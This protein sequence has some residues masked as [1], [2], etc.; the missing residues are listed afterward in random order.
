MTDRITQIKNNI[1]RINTDIENAVTNAHVKR[2]RRY[3]QEQEEWLQRELE[4]RDQS[5]GPVSL[6]T[7]EILNYENTTE[8]NKTG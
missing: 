5:S 2:L 8:E 4:K 6:F 3:R 1:E 7:G